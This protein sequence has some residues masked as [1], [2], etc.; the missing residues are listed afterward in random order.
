MIFKKDFR[1]TPLKQTKENAEANFWQQELNRYIDWYNGDIG[2]LYGVKSPV[3]KQKIK[4]RSVKDSAILTW[5]E[6]H[7]KPKYSKDLGLK[8]STFK[9]KRLLDVGAGPLPSG[10]VFKGSQLYCLDPLYSE[11]LSY[12]YPIHYY[13]GVTF[14]NSTAE[15]IP[16]ENNYFDAVIAVNAIDH[17]NDFAAT[18]KEIRRVLKADGMFAMHVHYHSATAAEPI[19]LNDAIFLKNYGWCK[20]LRKV[21]ESHKKTGWEISDDELYVVWRNF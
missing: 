4:A 13:P 19:E 8:P 15:D 18:A 2:E 12:G 1:Q 9:G 14:I 21:S 16:F 17:V 3:S 20:N 5:L 10:M 11:Y 6:L 7:Q